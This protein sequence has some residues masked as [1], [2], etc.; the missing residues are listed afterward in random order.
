M[1]ASRHPLVI[2]DRRGRALLELLRRT[3]LTVWYKSRCVRP[4]RRALVAL[5][6]ST[7]FSVLG[8]V[9]GIGTLLADATGAELFAVHAWDAPGEQL[10][11]CHC[12]RERAEEYVQ[13]RRAEAK[14]LLE[15]RLEL[16][17]ARIDQAHRSCERGDTCSVI[18]RVV[19]ERQIDALVLGMSRRPPV[20]RALLGCTAVRLAEAVPC[21]VVV[22]PSGEAMTSRASLP[23]AIA[24]RKAA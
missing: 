5:D 4:V 6:P 14:T 12:S 13:S 21:H 1:L 15:Q 17:D 16:A 7:S 18:T 23:R 2:T 22:I 10:L 19:L 8:R 11:R 20:A 3:D 9:L 24:L